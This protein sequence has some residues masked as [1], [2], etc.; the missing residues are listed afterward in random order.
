M[1][2]TEEMNKKYGTYH[3]MKHEEKSTK[4]LTS[5]MYVLSMLVNMNCVGFWRLN[6]GSIWEHLIQV[7]D[8][9]HHW[10]HVAICTSVSFLSF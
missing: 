4:I 2:M 9:S 8:Q 7:A 10:L 6:Q 1:Q 5:H 3:I